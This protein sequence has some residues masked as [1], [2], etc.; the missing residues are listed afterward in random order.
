VSE[1]PL[2]VGV[3]GLRG[4]V[5]E[6][7]TSDVTARYACSFGRWLTGETGRGKQVVVARDGRMGGRAVLDDAIRG[8]NA[9]GCTVIDLDVAMTPT[10]GI[11]VD[12]LGADAALIAT[13]SH[14]PQQWNG[15][16]ILLGVGGACAPDAA[17]AREIVSAFEG[18]DDAPEA[19]AVP[20]EVWTESA[21]THAERVVEAMRSSG[22][23]SGVVSGSAVVDSVNCSGA[24]GTLALQ[25]ALGFDLVEHLGSDTSGVFTHA[26]EPTAENLSGADGLCGVVPGRGADVGFAQDPDADRLAIIDENG[27]YI[28]EE[29]TLVLSAWSVLAAM[30]EGTLP[31]TPSLRRE[32]GQDVVLCT[33]LSTSRMIDDV[34][35]RFG[36]RVVRAAVGEANVVEA[37]RAHGSVIGGEG[38]GGV[39]WPAVTWVRD[40]LGSMGLVLALMAR[41]GKS[42]SRLVDEIN[43]LSGGGYSI[44]KRKTG[45]ASKA[46]ADP[47]C[48]AVASHWAD[49]RVDRQDGVRIDWIDAPGGG[50][51][52]WLHVRASNT[53]PIMRLI[54]EAGSAEQARGILDRAERVIAGG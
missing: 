12:R 40:S 39:I 31:P 46:A 26:P 34:A 41:T 37:M 2:M 19:S 4:I 17:T 51:K 8:L 54:A 27:A 42:V 3:S 52:A 49:E 36:A 24:A 13:A 29:Y 47:A 23:S 16:K 22:V 44:E 32:G 10:V 48:A 35:E 6:S 20:S 18:S 28:G 43:S 5:G 25:R 45:I 30:E 1:S 38:N 33:N 15:L 7:L 9:A 11:A 50:G 21:S 14:N 53:E